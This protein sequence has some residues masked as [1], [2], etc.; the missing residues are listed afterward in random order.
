MRRRDRHFR[1]RRLSG[2]ATCGNTSFLRFSSA[3]TFQSTSPDLRRTV[4]GIAPGS[5]PC[6]SSPMTRPVAVIGAGPGGLIAA[7]WLLSQGFE[8]TIFEQGPT[9]GGQW[10]GLVGRS[11]VWPAM[12][13]NTSRIMT[14]FSDLENKSD[15]VYPSNREILN[16]L[17]RYADTFGLTSRIR[18]GTRVELLRR[19]D[20][21]WLVSYAGLRGK[22]RTSGRREWQ[23]PCPRHPPCARAGHVRRL[24]RRDLHLPLPRAC[25][26]SGQAGSR[27]RLRYQRPRDRY[28][29]RPARRSSRCSDP[30][31]TAVRP[32]EVRRRSAFRSPNLHAIRNPRERDSPSRR[33]RPAAEGDRGRGWRK[34]GAVRRTRARPVDF[35]RRDHPQPAV[36]TARGRRTNFGVPLDEIHRGYDRGVRRRACRGV[37]RDCARHWV[38]SVPTVSE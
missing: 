38:R 34:S 37:R 3:R 36:P 9:L 17:H 8:P 10:T 28:G 30:A 12:H 22:L 26:I 4:K 35:R 14:A 11:G 32:A 20:A 15:L 18:F 2:C 23:I 7:R 5:R 33:E 6:D 29:T 1:R 25:S 27:G 31:P 24:G 21:G 16:Y 19:D 13:T